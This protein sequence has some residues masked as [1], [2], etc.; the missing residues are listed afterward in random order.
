MELYAKHCLIPDFNIA[1]SDE[2]V[3]ANRTFLNEMAEL[4]SRKRADSWTVTPVVIP[5]QRYSLHMTHIVGNVYRD[6]A[7]FEKW[8]H[9]SLFERSEKWHLRFYS[10]DV[11][12]L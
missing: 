5:V 7:L 3:K 1:G 12:T 11:E 10:V 6:A 8:R 2:A 4:L 9:I